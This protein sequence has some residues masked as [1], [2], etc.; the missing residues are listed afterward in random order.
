MIHLSKKK[1]KVNMI[2]GKDGSCTAIVTL[3]PSRSCNM[4]KG[5]Q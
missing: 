4:K 5:I 2:T 3:D 1:K